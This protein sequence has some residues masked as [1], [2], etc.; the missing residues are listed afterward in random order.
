MSANALK[1]KIAEQT[2]H[3]K[4]KS[5]DVQVLTIFPEP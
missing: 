2:L 4:D 3:L 5:S 1:K